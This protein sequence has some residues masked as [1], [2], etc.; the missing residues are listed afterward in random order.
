MKHSKYRHL[1]KNLVHLILTKF[2][3]F[4]LSVLSL[5][6]HADRLT[7]AALSASSHLITIA[8]ATSGIA[9]A[10]GA[11]F[12]HFGAPHL[13]KQ[14]LVGGIIGL[15]ATFGGPAIIE[16]LKTVFGA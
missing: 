7:Q 3:F 14:I 8:Q 5:N 12:Y 13:G 6:A 2:T 16:L 4:L 1:P 11:I 10:L 15:A 9:F